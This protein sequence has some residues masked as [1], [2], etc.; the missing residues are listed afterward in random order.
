MGA[1][2]AARQHYAAASVAYF[3]TAVH[4]PIADGRRSRDAPCPLRRTQDRPRDFWR[5]S[6][7]NDH[8]QL[9]HLLPVMIVDKAPA[10][11]KIAELNTDL[12]AKLTGNVSNPQLGRKRHDDVDQT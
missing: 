2:R 3:L 10:E 1:S 8:D 9:R 11:S 5:G 12:S 6:A 7:I 4:T